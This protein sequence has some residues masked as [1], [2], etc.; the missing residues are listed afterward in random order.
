MLLPELS[1]LNAIKGMWKFCNTDG[2][3]GDMFFEWKLSWQLASGVELGYVA[4]CF[5]HR[6]FCEV[7]RVF[8]VDN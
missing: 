8:I 3:K 6:I 1:L 7:L 5:R 2:R 4:G